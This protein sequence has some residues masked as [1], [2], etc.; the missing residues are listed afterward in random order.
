MA[1]LNISKAETSL[2]AKTYRTALLTD[3]RCIADH[4]LDVQC[5]FAGDIPGAE[6][7]ADG[8]GRHAPRGHAAAPPHAGPAAP[9]RHSALPQ[10]R[11]RC[12]VGVRFG[13]GVGVR[14]GDGARVKARASQPRP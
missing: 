10:A 13:V 7:R 5:R 6:G 14:V 8:P 2:V 12:V 3:I 11:R 9:R 4:D 1:P